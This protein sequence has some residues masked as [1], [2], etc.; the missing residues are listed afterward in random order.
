MEP[1]SPITNRVLWEGGRG[2]GGRARE[3][4]RGREGE[5]GRVREGVVLS[6]STPATLAMLLRLV[7]GAGIFCSIP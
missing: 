2:E 3:E 6:P 7:S 4:G 5:G 1:R